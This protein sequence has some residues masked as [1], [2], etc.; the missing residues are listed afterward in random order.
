VPIAFVTWGRQYQRTATTFQGFTCSLPH[1]RCTTLFAIQEP[2]FKTE[3]MK[4]TSSG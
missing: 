4:P 1:F 2:S 3:E